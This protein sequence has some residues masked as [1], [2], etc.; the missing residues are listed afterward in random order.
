[1]VV[2]QELSQLYSR[3][4]IAA[5]I[6]GSLFA[7]LLGLFVPNPFGEKVGTVGEY[8]RA[9]FYTVPVYLL[10]SF[11]V[12]L[13]GTITSTLSDFIAGFISNKRSKRLKI[14][15]SFI[16]HILFGLILLWYSLA[17]SILFFIT[18]YM[19]SRKNIQNWKSAFKSLGI[20]ILVWIAFMG[21][22]YIMELFR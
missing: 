9:F 19:L 10:Y 13:Y 7:I 17:A 12:L 16:L 22:V 2:K 11:P 20:P 21:S 1:M 8:I 3:K 6:S 4:V 18:D 14:Y 15:F 5:S